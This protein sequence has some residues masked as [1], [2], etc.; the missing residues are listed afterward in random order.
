MAYST[1]H[2][3]MSYEQYREKIGYKHAE[4]FRVCPE[5]LCR[6]GSF[7]AAWTVNPSKV[8]CDVCLK[9]LPLYCEKV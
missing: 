8:T 2:Y 6:N 9:R 4:D 7:H 3:A 1:M 5:K